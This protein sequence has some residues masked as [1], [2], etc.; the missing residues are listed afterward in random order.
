[1]AKMGRP[2]KQISKHTFEKLCGMQCTI[3]EV[4]AFLDVS[5]KTLEA[6]CKENYGMTFSKV[7]DQK[8]EA[9]KISLRRIQWQHAEKSPSMAIFLGKN[10]LNQRDVST[11]GVAMHVEDDPI[12]KALKESGIIDN[13]A[14]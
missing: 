12:T 10:Y 8:R 11:V 14:E 3:S 4:C 2:K 1:M 6:W 9:G 7:F 13:G 5:E